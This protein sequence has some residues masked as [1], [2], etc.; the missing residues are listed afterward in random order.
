MNK[1]LE[2]LVKANAPRLVVMFK[3][4]ED[5]SEQFQWGMSGKMPLLTL[6]GCVINAQYSLIHSQDSSREIQECGENAFVI[7]FDPDSTQVIY[8]CH[9]DIPTTPLVGMLETIKTALINSRVGQ[10]MVNQQT[11]ILGPD[12]KPMRS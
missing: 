2:E 9:K 8:F 5:G 10:H 12:G 6:V 7:A 11:P 1:T 4:Q 3:R